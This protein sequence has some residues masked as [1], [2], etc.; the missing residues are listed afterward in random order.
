M[1]ASSRVSFIDIA[2]GIGI[3]LVVI[4]HSGLRGFMS[5]WIWSFHMPLFFFISGVFFDQKKYN[6]LSRFLT[7]RLKTLIIPY[8]YFSIFAFSG[9][10]FLNSEPYVFKVEVF[11]YGWEGIALWFI[12]VLFAT[13]ILFFILRNWIEE[14]RILLMF[15]L[16]ISLLGYILTYN[17]IHFSYKLEVVFSSILFY[18]IGNLSNQLVLVKLPN[19]SKNNIL[20]IIFFSLFVNVLMVLINKP[21]LDLAWNQIGN[22]FAGYI[23]AFSGIILII[24]ISLLLKYFHCKFI[25][26]II[27]I[28]QNT[29]IVLACHQLFSVMLRKYINNLPISSPISMILRHLLLWMLLLLFVE[30]VNRYLP[31]VLSRKK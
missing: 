4:G 17:D 26:I 12:P 16:F 11:E 28:G 2:K 21:R 5:D 7:R 6:T 20:I 18:G 31:W 27:Y 15:L 19:L 9:F 14:N 3:F 22:Y 13:E 1:Q 10:L 24:S 30:I 25:N 29:F 8:I 23:G